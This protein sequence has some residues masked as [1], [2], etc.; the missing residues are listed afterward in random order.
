MTR[1]RRLAPLVAIFGSAVATVDGA[2]V[3]VG[4]GRLRS[5]SRESS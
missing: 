3:K 2:I 4:A 5:D 1:R